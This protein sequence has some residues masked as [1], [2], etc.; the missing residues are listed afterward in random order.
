MF[1][2]FG[3]LVLCLLSYILG[4]SHMKNKVVTKEVEV[5][6]YVDKQKAQI[7]S[8]PNASRDTL[9]GLMHKKVL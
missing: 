7:H 1:R 4:L 9:L 5:I 6:K 3:I 2:F 8:R